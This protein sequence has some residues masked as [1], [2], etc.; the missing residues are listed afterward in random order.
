ML[1]IL[2]N[3]FLYKLPYWLFNKDKSLRNSKRMPKKIHKGMEIKGESIG[4][5]RRVIKHF[6]VTI[7]KHYNGT[8]NRSN[9]VSAFM[10]LFTFEKELDEKYV[11]RLEEIATKIKN[12]ELEVDP[13]I[14]T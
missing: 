10:Y 4:V 1:Y 13:I 7:L 2:H 9:L 6:E 8:L 14:F 5:P 3:I 12:R 11:K